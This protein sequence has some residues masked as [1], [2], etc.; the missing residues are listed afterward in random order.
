MEKG[1]RKENFMADLFEFNKRR[2]KTETIWK[3]PRKNK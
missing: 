1:K 3:K 2:K